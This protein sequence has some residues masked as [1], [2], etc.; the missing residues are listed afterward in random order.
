LGSSR[1]T[2][3]TSP[4]FLF[5]EKDAH[6]DLHA[7]A[8][9]LTQSGKTPE[10]QTVPETPKRSSNVTAPKYPRE[11]K[12]EG[13]AARVALAMKGAPPVPSPTKAKSAPPP[14]PMKAPA[15]AKVMKAMKQ[16]KG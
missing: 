10:W 16:K 7:A 9:I 2:T 14:P 3:A 11:I 1:K 12:Q 6:D 5:P 8:Q 4:A 15:P 13:M